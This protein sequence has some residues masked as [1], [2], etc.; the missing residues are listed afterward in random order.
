M[1]SSLENMHSLTRNLAVG[2]DEPCHDGGITQQAEKQ[3]ERTDVR[4]LYIGLAILYM[5]AH[6]IGNEVMKP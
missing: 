2:L 6:R 4:M 5:G 1:T 3:D